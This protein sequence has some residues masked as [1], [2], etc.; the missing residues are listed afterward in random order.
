MNIKDI[1]PLLAV[2]SGFIALL[3]LAIAV[4]FL[5]GGKFVFPSKSSSVSAGGTVEIA[6]PVGQ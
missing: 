1:K 3:V 4:V 2:L 5:A 6:N